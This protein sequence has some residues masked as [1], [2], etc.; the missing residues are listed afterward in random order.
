MEICTGRA[1]SSHSRARRF[2]A[3]R[4]LLSKLFMKRNLAKKLPRTVQNTTLLIV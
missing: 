1:G 3:E 2:S 4:L